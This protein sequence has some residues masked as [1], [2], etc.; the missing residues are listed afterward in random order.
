LTTPREPRDQRLRLSSELRQLRRLA[1]LS[2][3]QMGRQVGVSQRTVSRYE[4]GVAI[5][6]LAHVRAWALAAQA[7][8]DRLDSLIVLAE[9]AVNEVTVFRD[10]LAAGL[11]GVQVSF[12]ELEASARTVR[13]FQPGIIPGLLQT[14]DYALRVLRIGNEV[15][16]DVDAA[17]VARMQ[18]QEALHQTGRTFEFLLTESALRWRPGP[19]HVVAAQ[20]LQIASL[21]SLETVTVGVI[22]ADAEMY[23][24]TRCGFALYEDRSDEQAPVVFIE[25]PHTALL[26]SEPEDVEVYQAELKRF[27]E[28]AVFGEEALAIIRALAVP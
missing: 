21:A 15:A 26:V 20:L 3:E 14:A 4:T 16:G 27:R 10:G 22:P 17:A 7:P 9:A 2:G 1:G 8:A 6:S 28:S 11:T 12:R 24:I 23:A 18:R 5:P 19:P 25:T 13:N